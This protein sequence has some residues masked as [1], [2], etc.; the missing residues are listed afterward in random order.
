MKRI[1]LITAEDFYNEVKTE[2]TDKNKDEAIKRVAKRFG[3]TVAEGEELFN[4]GEEDDYR[5]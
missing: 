2:G 3:L 1:G 5:D 4:V